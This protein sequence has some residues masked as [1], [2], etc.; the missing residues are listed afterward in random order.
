MH[1]QDGLATLY[2]IAHSFCAELQLDIVALQVSKRCCLGDSAP[3]T[4][5]DRIATALTPPLFRVSR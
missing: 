2:N 1:L 5:L 4:P 3:L